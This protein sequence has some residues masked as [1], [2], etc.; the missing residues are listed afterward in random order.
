M[1]KK[2][3]EEHVNH[4]RWLVSYADFITL[5]FAFF[6]VMFATAQV[7]HKRLKQV[8]GSIR[9]AMHFKGTGGLDRPPLFEGPS[10][11]RIFAQNMTGNPGKMQATL[12]ERLNLLRVKE[13]L[14][15]KLN[16]GDGGKEE[17]GRRSE[18]IVEVIVT[19]SGIRIRMTEAY[20]FDSGSAVLRPDAMPVV[21]TIAEVLKPLQ[22]HIR[23]EG[24]TDSE[25][26]GAHGRFTNWKLSAERALS[27]IQYLMVGFSYPPERLSLAAYAHTRPLTSNESAE[28]R[29]LNRRIDLFVMVNQ[30]TTT[31]N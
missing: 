29:A 12:S 20:F 13:E 31:V 19:E 3:H 7:D 15:K 16:S 25:G 4:E 1:K 2:K 24:H 23:V 5:L 18:G 21:D 10:T 26:A 9:F 8:V 22:R 6:V 14:E 27:I 28:G 11:E 17:A 30:E